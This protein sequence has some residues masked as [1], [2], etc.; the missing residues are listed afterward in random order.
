[1]SNIDLIKQIALGMPETEP[2]ITDELEVWTREVT[3]GL[4]RKK[5]LSYQLPSKE[6]SPTELIEAKRISELMRANTLKKLH[7]TTD[8]D[9][10]LIVV[11]KILE[12]ADALIKF[13]VPFRYSG[14]SVGDLNFRY[15]P[16][17]IVELK[18]DGEILY[19]AKTEDRV[20]VQAKSCDSAAVEASYEDPLEKISLELS[21]I[22]AIPKI[23]LEKSEH[24]K[25]YPLKDVQAA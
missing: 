10:K 1:M 23:L 21:D 19:V 20:L 8:S 18:H 7:A 12:W 15:N 14:Q 17:N 4:S 13:A 25:I 6:I 3:E 2:V 24:Q 22:A 9:E 5:R 16:N 11:S